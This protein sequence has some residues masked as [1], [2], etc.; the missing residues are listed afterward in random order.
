[1]AKKRLFRSKKDKMLG[2][3]CGGIAEYFDWDPSMVRIVTAL[4]II[5]T[6][7]FPFILLYI[8]AWMVV[9]ENPKK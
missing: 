2:G 9:P 7:F 1:M 8:I 5:L 6:G 4:L 3:V